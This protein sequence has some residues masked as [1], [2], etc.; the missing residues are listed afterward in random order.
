[1]SQLLLSAEQLALITSKEM[2]RKTRN[3]GRSREDDVDDGDSDYD[4]LFGNWF[5]L[6]YLYFKNDDHTRCQRQ[7]LVPEDTPKS[8]KML[9]DET[10]LKCGSS[11]SEWV[12]NYF[13]VNTRAVSKTDVE[14]IGDVTLRMYG[15]PI[16]MDYVANIRDSYPELDLGKPFKQNVVKKVVGEP[17]LFLDKIP[18]GM[19]RNWYRPISTT[20]FYAH[21]SEVGKGV[22]LTLS[23][24]EDDIKFFYKVVIEDNAKTIS[25]K[26]TQRDFIETCLSCP[27]TVEI[28]LPIGVLKSGK[29]GPGMD[30][31]SDVSGAD[32]GSK[33]ALLLIINKIHKDIEIF[34]PMGI[35]KHNKYVKDVKI[36]INKTLKKQLP[37]LREYTILSENAVCPR[38]SFQHI[39]R[40]QRGKKGKRL[41]HYGGMCSFWVLWYIYYRLMN[42]HFDRVY[43][44]N[45]ALE[46]FRS[47][48]CTDAYISR[49]ARYV[50]DTSV[51]MLER[52]DVK[53]TSTEQELTVN[54]GQL[55]DR[56][57]EWYRTSFS[58]ST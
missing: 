28:F 49:F 56:L 29:R 30:D 52:M 44:A 43:L 6:P 25:F 53:M 4:V 11:D 36:F 57:T 12:S 17:T 19:H 18:E 22:C 33:H 51:K 27:R 55:K 32:G 46:Y 8:V 31:G 24:N 20:L 48:G 50:Q 54:F 23:K 38:E 1:M 7:Y 21:M 2:A 45:Y 10:K 15:S 9:I 41:E 5:H 16:T 37:A 40:S 3:K 13:L 26:A 58:C 34:D 35:K 42:P 39:E 47:C 14:E